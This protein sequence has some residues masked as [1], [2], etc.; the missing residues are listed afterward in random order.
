ML[1]RN[2]GCV[3]Y[4][5]AEKR[6]TVLLSLTLQIVQNLT[7]FSNLGLTQMHWEEEGPAEK[8]LEFPSWLSG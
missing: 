6:R 1:M 7:D 5:A 3:E 4:N 2:D 8:H